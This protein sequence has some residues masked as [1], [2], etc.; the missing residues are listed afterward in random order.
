MPF[1][2]GSTWLSKIYHRTWYWKREDN[3]NVLK[4][5]LLRCGRKLRTVS[6]R[7]TNFIN[8]DVTAEVLLAPGCPQELAEKCPNIS[9]MFKCRTAPTM[10]AMVQYAELVKPYC[11][12]TK[13]SLSEDDY[14]KPMMVR[15]LET[16]VMVKR[17]FILAHTGQFLGPLADILEKRN[18]LTRNQLETLEVW[19]YNLRESGHE[20][21]NNVVRIINASPSL[22]TIFIESPYDMTSFDDQGSQRYKNILQNLRPPE[23]YEHFEI[24]DCGHI[25]S[26]LAP[27]VGHHLTSLDLTV[28]LVEDHEVIDIDNRFVKL[29]T[30]KLESH[31]SAFYSLNSNH[32]PSLREF[33]WFEGDEE[34]ND[35]QLEESEIARFVE[36]NGSKLTT[37]RLD[38]KCR[39]HAQL[40]DVIG[41]NCK[42]LEFL[43]IH[44]HQP[45]NTESA[46]NQDMIDKMVHMDSMVEF[47]M[48]YDP[49]VE[50]VCSG[51]VFD[52]AINGKLNIYLDD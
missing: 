28:T 3:R 13:L 50:P 6:F 47:T 2:I 40:C 10:E 17:L 36:R 51:F 25:L 33:E 43:M 8:N 20:H 18:V 14:C 16:C 1:L 45:I 27:T 29:K 49:S 42:Q 4:A 23:G 52:D 48:R 26:I 15:L 44:L 19:T 31:R 11:Q 9:Q 32:Y 5:I 38:F 37:L 30:F 46:V 22:K 7:T 24:F 34:E 12:F 39:N 21:L 35:E 41:T